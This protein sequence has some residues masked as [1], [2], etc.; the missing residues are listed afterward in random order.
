VSLTPA[1]D[2]REPQALK[3]GPLTHLHVFRVRPDS[4]D[5]ADVD[6]ADPRRVIIDLVQDPDLARV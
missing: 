4:A 3:E 6:D 5:H 2:Q 1:A